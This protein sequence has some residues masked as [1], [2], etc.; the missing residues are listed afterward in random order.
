[1]NI[2]HNKKWVIDSKMD[3]IRSPLIQQATKRMKFALFRDIRR[4]TGV[5]VMRN[6]IICPDEIR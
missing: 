2:G 4:I 6:I 1:M 3:M 5:R